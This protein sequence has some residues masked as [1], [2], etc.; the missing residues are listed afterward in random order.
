LRLT[1]LF[2][3]PRRL[4]D[5][6]EPY[7]RAHGTHGGVSRH[8]RDGETL[9]DECATFLA[10][11]RRH[12]GRQPTTTTTDV[13]RPAQEAAKLLFFHR[14]ERAKLRATLTPEER[15]RLDARRLN[16]WADEHGHTVE[17]E[18]APEPAVCPRHGPYTPHSLVDADYPRC[19][20]DAADA[21]QNR[22]HDLAPRPTPTPS[23]EEEGDTWPS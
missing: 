16:T 10:N 19:D 1:D 17:P 18:P 23:A 8:H 21:W 12:H 2:D 13:G 5:D 11:Y 4:T 22:R 15:A 6:G 9:C 7:S 14:M 3:N 20:H